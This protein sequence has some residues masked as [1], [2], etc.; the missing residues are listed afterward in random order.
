M[1][2]NHILGRN[3]MTNPPI[4][5][6]IIPTHNRSHSLVQ[7]LDTILKQT[8]DKS[9]YEII[10]VDNNSDDDTKDTIERL[11]KKNKNI[12][13]F[14]EPEQGLHYARHKGAKEAKAEILLFTDDDA[15]CDKNWLKEILNQFADNTIDAVGGRIQIKWDKS[16]PEWVISH[17]EAL[18]KLDYGPKEK[19]LEPFQSIAGGNFAIKRER[20]YEVGGF[21][22]DQY[23]D[24]LLG[25]G[26][27]GLCKKMHLNKYKIAWAPSALVHHLQYVEKNATLNDLKRRFANNGV[28][29]AYDYYKYYRPSSIRLFLLSI[30]YVGTLLLYKLLIFFR[31]TNQD[32]KYDLK[33]SF[34]WAKTKYLLTLIHNSNMRKF[35]LK[36]DW[37]KENS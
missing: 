12:K 15:L 20:L 19:I 23:G 3:T 5:S 16:P 35:V 8:L 26:E 6:V 17:E 22:P 11:E 36:S 29:S 10:V 28:C 2:D 18:G 21:N 37:L 9:K 33:S 25:D 7:T 34:L 14:F 4:I 13:Y 32:F 31:Q 1:V 27:T 24:V 30:I